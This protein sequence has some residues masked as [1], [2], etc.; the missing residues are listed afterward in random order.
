V[1]LMTR[2]GQRD[3]ERGE[4]RR[5]EE[6]RGEEREG[7]PDK[8]VEPGQGREEKGIVIESVLSSSQQC[9]GRAGCVIV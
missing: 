4:E 5:G 9:R 2:G 1:I 3:R 8:V 7:N 6:R